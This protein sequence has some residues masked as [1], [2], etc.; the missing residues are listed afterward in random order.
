MKRVLFVLL[1]PVWLVVVFIVVFRLTFPSDAIVDRA[2]YEVGN[3]TG[4]AM[5]LQL[6]SVSP[7]WMGLTGYDLLLSSVEEGVAT[8]MFAVEQL[9]AAGGLM[10][11]INRAPTVAGYARFGDGR[12][13][14]DAT[15]AGDDA[16]VY[17]MRNL[18]VD[19]QGFPLSA[20]PP[21][22]GTKIL[23][24]GGFDLDVDLDVPD[25]Y[26]KSNG[27][28]SLSAA[29]IELSGVS[30]D[31]NMIVTGFGILP[32]TIER[33]D[34]ELEIREGKAEVRRGT[35]VSS[36]ADVTIEG[37][38]VLTN[39]LSNSRLRLDLVIDAKEPLQG[40]STLMANALWDT[41]EKY[42][43]ELRG[44]FN[45]P[46]FSPA[47][48]RAATRSRP[49][50]ASRPTRR[51]RDN[52]NE[53]PEVEPVTGS[54]VTR[55]RAQPAREQLRRR[56]PQVEGIERAGGVMDGPNILGDGPV[57]PGQNEGDT[58]EPAADPEEATE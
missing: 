30:G 27:R 35:L 39:R 21:I 22:Q 42:H 1:T 53:P 50:P 14:F 38:I 3:A 8:P 47:R 28:A 55:D 32:A 20:L 24:T 33:L 13:N 12:L 2:S 48:N 56:G 25:G 7:A 15:I 57:I 31:M 16:G 19:A 46:S 17:D 10:S 9:K 29:N 37:D 36:L 43:Y 18:D 44:N 34:L 52:T 51:G 45:R 58:A 11:L 5:A 6:G 49:R 26:A 40:L 41:D 54:Q 23:G 4:G